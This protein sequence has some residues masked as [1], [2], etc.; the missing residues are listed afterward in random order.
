MAT[1]DDNKERLSYFTNRG[2]AIDVFAAGST[3]LSPYNTGYYD[4][5]NF[6]YYNNYLSGTSMATPN[7]AGLIS[8]HLESNPKANRI[9]VR[10]WLLNNA[11]KDAPL[12]NLYTDDSVSTYWSNNYALRGSNPRVL[13]NPYAN[14]ESPKVEGIAASGIS[15]TQS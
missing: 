4:P 10:N 2:P 7:V 5:R 6:S 1:T 13:F 14:N 11:T 8:L 3:I 12:S 9:D 15:F